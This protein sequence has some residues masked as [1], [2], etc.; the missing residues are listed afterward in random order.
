MSKETGDF[1]K[2][3][4]QRRRIEKLREVPSP[5]GISTAILGGVVGGVVA[6]PIGAISGVIAGEVAGQ[7]LDR[8]EANK[9]EAE[10]KQE[11]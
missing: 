8:K 10:A 4:L 6:G 3:Y 1:E 9:L 2:Q 11:G 7:L 5:M